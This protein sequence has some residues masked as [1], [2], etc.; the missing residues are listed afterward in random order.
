MLAAV[1]LFISKRKQQILKSALQAA[2][3]TASYW[4]RFQ[5]LLDEIQI[6]L[7]AAAGARSISFVAR[8]VAGG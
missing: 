5:D 1:L 4:V 8:F 2:V 7:H 3:I 6:T